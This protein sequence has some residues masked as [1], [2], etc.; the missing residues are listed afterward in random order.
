MDTGD[1]KERNN[2]LCEGEALLLELNMFASKIRMTG[3]LWTATQPS[4]LQATYSYNNKSRQGKQAVE[5]SET[6]VNGSE[7][8]GLKG[9]SAGQ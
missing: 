8:E 9:S 3:A 2:E 5:R 7:E 6:E 4:L 1:N